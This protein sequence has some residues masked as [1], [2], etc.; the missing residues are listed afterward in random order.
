MSEPQLTGSHPILPGAPTTLGRLGVEL[1]VVGFHAG[2]WLVASLMTVGWTVALLTPD[3]FTRVSWPVVATPIAAGFVIDMLA[4][5]LS[6]PRTRWLRGGSLVRSP[7]PWP[8]VLIGLPAAPFMLWLW[9]R[10]RRCRPSLRDGSA[11]IEATFE[12]L[13]SL[14]RRAAIALGATL[15]PALASA[16][17]VLITT[18]PLPAGDAVS[19]ALLTLST[20]LPFVAVSYS[21]T[22]ALL[23]PELLSAPRDPTR[24]LKWRR[25]LRVRLMVPAGIACIGA[26]LAPLVTAH[27]WQR[28]KIRGDAVIAA[29]AVASEIML[30]RGVEADEALGRFLALHPDVTIVQGR[31]TYGPKRDDMPLVSGPM[32]SDRDGRPESFGLVQGDAAAV[33][34]IVEPIVEVPRLLGLSAFCIVLAGLVCIWLISQGVREDVL[35][36]GRQV[37]RVARGLVPDPLR[38]DSF[39]TLELRELVRAVDRL[40]ARIAEANVAKFVVIEKAQEADRLRSQFLANMSHDLR[41]PLNSV[42]GFSELLLTG[43]DGQLTDA[44]AEMCSIIQSSGRFLLQQIDDILDTA[45]VDAGRME[46]HAEPTPPATLISRAVKNA[47]ERLPKNLRIETEADAGLPPTFADPYRAVQAIENVLVFAA[48]KVD[49]DGQLLVRASL[50]RSVA[51]RGRRVLVEVLTPEPP[52]TMAQLDRV[53]EGFYRI[54]GH[55]GLGL[56]LPLAGGVLELHGGSLDIDEVDQHMRF[57]LRFPVPERRKRSRTNPRASARPPASTRKS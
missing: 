1:R 57:L 17:M 34:P 2:L 27:M 7:S 28:A 43:I 52:A 55:R 29:E 19:W 45:K 6:L 31:R 26:V 32:D 35:R 48:E 24:R 36:A 14:P 11:K 46:L 22:H 50:D 49:D 21:R 39:N 41:S 18:L 12:S 8:L 20:S 47:R 10:D 13:T 53:L 37:R 9:W 33:V 23:R 51:E 42:L 15:G 44:Q 25:D 4:L 5:L 16:A 3:Q 30:G 40:V 56:G 54:P 38:V